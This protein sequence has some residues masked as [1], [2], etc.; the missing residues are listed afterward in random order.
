MSKIKNLKEKVIIT[1][2][3][4]YKI[5][6]WKICW[7]FFILSPEFC[8]LTS[9]D[10]YLLVF[11]TTFGPDMPRQKWDFRPR[12]GLPG[13]WEALSLSS[14]GEMPPRWL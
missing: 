3:R 9:F 13:D 7:G 1:K 6:K 10:D 14:Y 8:I 5:T 2:T 4:K 11:S 12:V